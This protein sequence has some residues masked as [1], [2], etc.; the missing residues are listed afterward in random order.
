M[1]DTETAL[2]AEDN[3]DTVAEAANDQATETVEVSAED[4]AQEQAESMFDGK[5]SADSEDAATDADTEEQAAKSDTESDEKQDA[6]DDYDA[7]TLPEGIEMN[8]A[9]LDQFKPL[10]KEAGLDQE[11]AQKFVDLYTAAM[12]EAAES[13]QKL[14]ADTQQEW[15]D[16]AKTDP[17]IGGDKFD[18]NLGDAKRAIK[19]FGTP[20]LEDALSITGAGNHPEFIRLMARVGK[21]IS[22]DAMIPGRATTGPRTAEQILYP[23]MGQEP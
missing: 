9:A 17:E 5:S 23:E 11:N 7:F 13:Q 21:A 4:H 18:S 12:V 2:A 20:E 10:A 22:E 15:V 8:D 14:W 19:E 6:P 1:A 16:Q 3:T